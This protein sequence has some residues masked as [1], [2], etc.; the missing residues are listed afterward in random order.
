[1]IRASIACYKTKL[2]VTTCVSVYNHENCNDLLIKALVNRI[3][4]RPNKKKK[5]LFPITN[6]LSR[7]KMKILSFLL[8]KRNDL[9]PIT[10]PFLEKNKEFKS[11]FI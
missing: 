9:F 5:L 7:K 3:F 10:T 6:T 2:Q 1:M 8:N 4:V 11:C